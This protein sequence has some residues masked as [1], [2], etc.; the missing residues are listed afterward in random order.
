MSALSLAA[1]RAAI[2]ADWTS[3]RVVSEGAWWTIWEGVLTPNETS[4]RV[5]VT[6]ERPTLLRSGVLLRPRHVFPRVVVLTPRLEPR[7]GRLPHVYHDPA[8]PPAST[9][10]L[11]L[12]GDEW[13]P[14]DPLTETILPWAS[15]W[16]YYYEFWRETDVWIGGGMHVGEPEYDA[17]EKAHGPPA[18][19][20]V[21]AKAGPYRRS[22]DNYAFRLTGTFASFPWTAAG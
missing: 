4:Y 15:L 10:C 18:A 14:G 13:A 6:L 22:A 3:F 19:L 8:D 1:Q 11:Y 9:L 17:W 20:D 21:P 16:L 12:P 7:D 2:A 5:R